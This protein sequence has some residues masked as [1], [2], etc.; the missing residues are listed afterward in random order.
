MDNIPTPEAVQNLRQ[1]LIY[2]SSRGPI[3]IDSMVVTVAVRSYDKL[4]RIHGHSILGTPLMDALARRA[5]LEGTTAS[6]IDA[7]GKQMLRR[8]DGT[9]A[10]AWYR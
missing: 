7:Q 8:S 9:Y 2:Q 4:L 10:G 6:P 5:Q 1:G 3:E